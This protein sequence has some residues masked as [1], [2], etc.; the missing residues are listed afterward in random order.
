MVDEQNH[1]KIVIPSVSTTH[2]YEVRAYHAKTCL[3][4]ILSVNLS[5]SE[6]LRC[7]SL[8]DTKHIYT[9]CFTI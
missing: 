5:L 9:M 7:V 2:I 3:Q 1:D 6:G 8:F 4:A